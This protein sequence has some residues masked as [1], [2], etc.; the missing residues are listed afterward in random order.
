MLDRR[1]LSDKI[2][3]VIQRQILHG[4]L[5]AGDYLP[6]ESALAAL[7]GVNRATVREAIP[8]LCERGLVEKRSGNRLRIK[9]IQ[10]GNIATVLRHIVISNNCSHKELHQFRGVFEAKVAALAAKNAHA[11]DLKKLAQVLQ[12]LEAA[13]V[14]KEVQLLAAMDAQFHLDLSAASHNALMLAM[15]IGLSVIL[16]RFMKTTHALV[17]SEVSFRT[18]RLIYQAIVRRNQAEAEEAMQEQLATQPI[19]EAEA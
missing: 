19:V 1:K 6:P 2:A 10:P 3:G 12:A 13:W 5:K 7:L 16:E 14:N 15:G 17:R 11:D 18:H 4:K 8:L 9:A